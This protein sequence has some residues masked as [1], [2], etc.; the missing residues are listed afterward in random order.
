MSLMAF[1]RLECISAYLVVEIREEEK[2][3][4]HVDDQHVLHPHGEVTANPEQYHMS[5]NQSSVYW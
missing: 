3:G 4:G 2:E 5:I 1:K